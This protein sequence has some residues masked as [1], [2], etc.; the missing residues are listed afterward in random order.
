MISDIDRLLDHE[1]NVL[2]QASVYIQALELTEE[3]ISTED[4]D[5]KKV[6][7]ELIVSVGFVFHASLPSSVY[8]RS[9]RA[10][11]ARLPCTRFPV[12]RSTL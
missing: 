4:I 12:N 10:F 8:S 7:D 6:G 3:D 5:L 2:S 11:T 9:R 1:Y